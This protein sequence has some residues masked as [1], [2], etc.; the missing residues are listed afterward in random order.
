MISAKVTGL[1]FIQ[2]EPWKSAT[3]TATVPLIPWPMAGNSSIKPAN[4]ESAPALATP[5]IINGIQV[6]TPITTP[7]AN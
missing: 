3:N 2:V 6:I 4:S 1:T 7:S 5:T